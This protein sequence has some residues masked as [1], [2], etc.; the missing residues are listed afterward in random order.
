MI[1]GFLLLIELILMVFLLRAVQRNN[2]NPAETDL[3]FF[4]FH[5]NPTNAA[6]AV[7]KKNKEK[8][9]HA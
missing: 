6:A 7:K 9:I 2:K 8:G 4:A 5:Q 3:G 1:E